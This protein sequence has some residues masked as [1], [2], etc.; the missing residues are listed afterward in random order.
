[1]K[2]S[3]G[4]R[5]LQLKR[6]LKSWLI[7]TAL[8]LVF[9]SVIHLAGAAE[10]ENSGESIT[11]SN[12]GIMDRIMTYIKGLLGEENIQGSGAVSEA[13]ISGIQ[14]SAD[15]E[16]AVLKIATPGMVKSTSFIGD[17]NLG[18]FAHLSNPLMKWTQV[19]TYK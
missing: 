9:C 6:G 17:S 12:D 2:K 4:F 13:A 8:M 18:V 15:S 5:G 16:K 10:P 1:M 7:F 19:E 14:Q 11:P 3:K